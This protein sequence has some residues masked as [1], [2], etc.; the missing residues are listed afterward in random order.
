MKLDFE[1]QIVRLPPTFSSLIFLQITW[2]FFFFFFLAITNYL[3]QVAWKSW[4][5][6]ALGNLGG[7]LRPPTNYTMN[8]K[9]KK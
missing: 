4:A 5:A 2:F 3:R 6:Q 9:N 7:R 1:G 8:A